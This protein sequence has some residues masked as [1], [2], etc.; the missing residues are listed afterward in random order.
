MSK[1]IIE[2]E[3]SANDTIICPAHCDGYCGAT[4]NDCFGL[5]NHD[6][7]AKPALDLREAEIATLQKQLAEAKASTKRWRRRYLIGQKSL[8]RRT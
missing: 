5:L 6:C 1:Y 8:R 2:F 7:P 3:A 4:T